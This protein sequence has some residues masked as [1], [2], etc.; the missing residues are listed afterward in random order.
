M[1]IEKKVKT[2]AEL[3]E[4]LQGKIGPHYSAEFADNRFT[5]KEWAYLFATAG[6]LFR[7]MLAD[8][9]EK[10]PDGAID[11]Y[12]YLELFWQSFEGREKIPINIRNELYR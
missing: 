12:G 9:K 3:Q 10:V 4:E 6:K 2:L 1:A 8:T 11:V 5:L 7:I